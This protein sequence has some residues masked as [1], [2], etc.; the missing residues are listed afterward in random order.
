[1]HDWRATFASRRTLPMRFRSPELIG[2][3]RHPPPVLPT[4]TKPPD[5]PPGR[6]SRLWMP[7][8]VSLNPGRTLIYYSRKDLSAVNDVLAHGDY[9]PG[10]SAAS[11]AIQ[12]LELHQKD[13]NTPL[14]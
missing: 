10:T 6:L 13:C 1:M 8:R 2:S 12:R 11:V 7:A 3:D 5:E 9:Q 4:C 14:L